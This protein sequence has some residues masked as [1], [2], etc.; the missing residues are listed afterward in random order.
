MIRA[1]GSSMDL[2]KDGTIVLSG[3]DIV[4]QSMRN[5]MLKAAGHMTLKGA[6]IKQN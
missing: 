6:S 4:L 3:Q 2:R 1:G 5:M